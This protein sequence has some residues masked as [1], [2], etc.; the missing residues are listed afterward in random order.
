[1][2]ASDYTQSLRT[3]QS[4]Q[5][6]MLPDASGYRFLSLDDRQSSF[7]VASASTK[8]KKTTRK[9]VQFRCCFAKPENVA[10]EVHEYEKEDQRVLDS[11]FW[12]SEE[13]HECSCDAETDIEH[14][15]SDYS[16]SLFLAYNQA[17]NTDNDSISI[18]LEQYSIARG[19]EHDI[20]PE[21]VHCIKRHRQAVLLCQE[22]LHQIQGRRSHGDGLNEYKCARALQLL[23]QKYSRPACLV[24][25]KLAEADSISTTT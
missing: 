19:L 12:T 21:A 3:F 22:K 17:L 20:F 16:E 8:T 5:Q 25:L 11:L 23:S 24:A 1:M 9:S 18:T 6:I 7:K 2:V 15:T 13:L 4:R 14:M 10:C